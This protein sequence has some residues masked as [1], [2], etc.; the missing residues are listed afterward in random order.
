MSINLNDEVKVLLQEM[1]KEKLVSKEEN[2]ELGPKHYEN[3]KKMEGN[4]IRLQDL[5][6]EGNIDK[7]EYEQA[8]KRYQSILEELNQK[9]EVNKDKKE[10]LKTYE[11]ALEKLLTIHYQYKEGDIETKRKVIGSIFPEKFQFEKNKVRTKDINP[12][13]LKISCINSLSQGTK[14]RTNSKKLNLS[15]MV[16]DEGFEP[17]TPSV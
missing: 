5:Y 3:I 13:F 14:K 15:R 4:L 10:L 11:L 6:I 12:L 9:E 2:K 8:R 17:P 1:I 16:G 7:A